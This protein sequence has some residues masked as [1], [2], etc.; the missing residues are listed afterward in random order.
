MT[1]TT[2]GRSTPVF[3]AIAGMVAALAG[4]GT[5]AHAVRPAC[6]ITNER[7]DASYGTL[8]AAVDDAQPGDLVE[9]KGT[10]TGSTTIGKDVQIKG[11]TNRAFPG[12][13]TLVGPGT[14][15]VL[16][17]N[18]GTTTGLRNLTITGGVA[19]DG[20]GIFVRPGAATRVENSVIAANTASGFGGGIEV[21]P[22]GTLTVVDSVVHDNS[23][24]SSGGI[25]SDHGTV[26]VVSSA[27]RDN[28]ARGATNCQ[29]IGSCAGGLW[30]FGGAM[31][32]IDTAITG[33][34]ASFRGGGLVNQTPDGEPPAV[35]ALRGSTTVSHNQADDRGGGL[36]DRNG[37]YDVT[38]WTGSIFQNTPDDCFPS[39]PALGC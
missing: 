16:R 36:F 14:G 17:L 37:A 26:T 29:D 7:T 25:D 23:A 10:C 24:G 27:V 3:V 19:S 15:R 13:A 30:N 5:V 33:N 28:T 4:G 11:V 12:P 39:V 18:E 32:L 34:S 9:V 8:Q 6:E 35:V 31:T 20:G 21:F 38:G 1:R 2:P 22:G